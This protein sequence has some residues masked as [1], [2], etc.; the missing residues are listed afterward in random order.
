MSNMFNSSVFNQSIGNWNVTSVTRMHGMFRGNIV[1]NQDLSSWDVTGVTRC[2]NFSLNTIEWTLPEP[3]FTN[4][5]P[6]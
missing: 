4:C 6:N 5:D 1:F 2:D 3:N